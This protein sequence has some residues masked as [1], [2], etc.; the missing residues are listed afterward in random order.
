[1]EGYFLDMAFK[2]ALKAY[3][4]GEIPVGCVIVLDNKVIASA[5]NLKEMYK[6]ATCHAEILAIKE[7]SKFCDDWRL[8]NCVLYTTVE[9]C[10]MCMGAIRESRI[11][12]VVYSV[13]SSELK[14][15]YRNIEVISDDYKYVESLNL[16]K[17]F[18]ELRRRG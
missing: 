12:K 8:D 2:E 9:P 14:K 15:Y 4:L 6:D 18:F 1:M 5:H 3:D 10:S 17:S 13:P 16:L 7:A 11:S